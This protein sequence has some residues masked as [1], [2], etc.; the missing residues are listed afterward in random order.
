MIKARKSTLEYAASLLGIRMYSAAELRKKLYAKEYPAA[1]IRQVIEDF[2]RKGYLN[3]A[4]Y[5]ENLCSAMSARGD[6]K[7]KIAGRLRTKGIDPEI[8]GT[9]LQTLDGEFPE[10]EAAWQ[11]LQKKKIPLMRESDEQKRKEKAVRYLAGHG[12]SASAA[13]SAWERFRQEM[14]GKE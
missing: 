5:A 2:I 3:D 14:T 12:F 6:G 4:L 7:R 11:S 1:E 8:I 10:D 13:F 9:I